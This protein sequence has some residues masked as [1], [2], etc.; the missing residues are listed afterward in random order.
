[1][2]MVGV[3]EYSRIDVNPPVCVGMGIVG[4]LKYPRSDASVPVCGVTA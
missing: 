3:L 2:R 4:M 1:M